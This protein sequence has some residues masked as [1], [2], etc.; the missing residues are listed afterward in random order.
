MH[1]SLERPCPSWQ[2]RRVRSR[3]LWSDDVLTC[4]GNRAAFYREQILTTLRRTERYQA[5]QTVAELFAFRLKELLPTSPHRVR[6]K[7]QIPSTRFS[8]HNQ[9]LIKI[10]P[11]T[12]AVCRR[13]DQM[14]RYA[15][16]LGVL[17]AL[18]ALIFMLPVS[19][20]SLICSAVL[21]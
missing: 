7:T 12:K 18:T 9:H 6:T 15:A 5:L 14:Y 16:L 10:R 19:R 11:T 2:R 21:R 3:E 20:P 1:N 8:K 17:S 13:L 4:L